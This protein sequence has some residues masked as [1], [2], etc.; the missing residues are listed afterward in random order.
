MM[1]C[2]LADDELKNIVASCGLKASKHALTRIRQRLAP[3][4]IEAFKRDLEMACRKY[5]SGRVKKQSKLRLTKGGVTTRRECYV[6]LNGVT[7][8][9]F[10]D[11]L[12]SVYV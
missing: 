11:F 7:Y 5:R 6:R 4:Q 2:E 10:K 9:F 1:V 3:V 8:V 12:V